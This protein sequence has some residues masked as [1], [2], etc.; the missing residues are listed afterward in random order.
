MIKSLNAILISSSNV[1]KSIEFYKGLGIPLA[2]HDHGQGTHAEADIEDFHFAI[3][4]GGNKQEQRPNIR[5]SFNVPQLESF[6]ED[7]KTKGYEFLAPPASKPFGGITADLLD[8]DGNI[9]TLMR[10]ESE[11]S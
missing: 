10:W 3:F 1:S 4:P 9:V 5:F 6:Y 11:K 2:I 8:P 7:L